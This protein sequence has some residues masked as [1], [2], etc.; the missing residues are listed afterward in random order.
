M[1]IIPMKKKE[2]RILVVGFWK[3]FSGRMMKKPF[4]L[5]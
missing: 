5:I 3:K 4:L 1:K 2:N